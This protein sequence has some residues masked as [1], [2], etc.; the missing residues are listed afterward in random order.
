VLVRPLGFA[1]A[2]RAL[3][4]SL[5]QATLMPHIQNRGQRRSNEE[6]LQDRTFFNAET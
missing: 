4:M 3:C 1:P 5:N 6:S 2:R